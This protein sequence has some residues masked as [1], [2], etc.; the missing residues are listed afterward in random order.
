MKN[1][2]MG[3][4]MEFYELG[5]LERSLNATFIALVPKKMSFVGEIW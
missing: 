3:F 1:E 5:S 4:F 2:V